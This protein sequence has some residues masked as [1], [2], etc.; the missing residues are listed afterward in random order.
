MPDRLNAA[1]RRLGRSKTVV[2]Q[3]TSRQWQCQA[4]GCTFRE[5]GTDI[6]LDAGFA[7]IRGRR[8]HLNSNCQLLLSVF[9]K[10][11][12]HLNTGKNPVTIRVL[13]QPCLGE[14]VIL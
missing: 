14:L 13:F 6:F 11:L 8:R 7:A 5:G 1:E 12:H 3:S 4:T 10:A 2:A 9:V